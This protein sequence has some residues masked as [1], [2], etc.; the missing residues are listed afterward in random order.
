ME[1]S[2]VDHVISERHWKSTF[3][4]TEIV[5]N[6]GLQQGTVCQIVRFISQFFI[7]LYIQCFQSV[8]LESVD[9]GYCKK[10]RVLEFLAKIFG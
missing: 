5:N 6:C 7:K 10:N 9:R 1:P 3:D 2:T 8:V 4:F